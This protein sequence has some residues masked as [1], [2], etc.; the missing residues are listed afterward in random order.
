MAT[1]EGRIRREHAALLAHVK[2]L[3]QFAN[4]LQV[5]DTVG[6]LRVRPLLAQALAPAAE[7]KP[8]S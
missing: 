1:D 4:A 8:R 2:D 3:A 7:P 6:D 5:E